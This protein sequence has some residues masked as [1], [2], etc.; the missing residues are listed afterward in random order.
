MVVTM[1]M[2]YNEATIVE[3]EQQRRTKVFTVIICALMIALAASLGVILSW[4]TLLFCRHFH[5]EYG[6]S[7]CQEYYS[8]GSE[9]WREWE[10]CT[11]STQ[12]KSKC[13]GSKYSVIAS[14]SA[15]LWV[16]LR[17]R[18][19]VL[20]LDAVTWKYVPTVFSAKISVAAASTQM[21]ASSSAPQ[22]VGSRFFR[23]LCWIF[24]LHHQACGMA[25]LLSIAIV[26]SA[27][28]EQQ[29]LGRWPP[30]VYPC[31]WVQDFGRLCR[32]K[33][34]TLEKLA[35]Y[36]LFGISPKKWFAATQLAN[37]TIRRY[38][39]VSCCRKCTVVS[40]MLLFPTADTR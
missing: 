36:C 19:A 2:L 27:A 5:Y 3:P 37:S 23:R 6:Y 38:E 17:L 14:S 26:I 9:S 35:C 22:W 13:C 39:S 32:L 33:R 1:I 20:V 30:E 28:A 7:T 21:T 12:C 29:V 25:F 8:A 11:D 40:V 4:P 10:T 18:K 15:P 24:H 34:N 16:G 31:G